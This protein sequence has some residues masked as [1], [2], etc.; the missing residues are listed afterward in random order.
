MDH[1]ELNEILQTFQIIV[2]TR[3][4]NTPR[5]SERFRAFGA[6][7]S[8]ATLDYGD[9]CGNILLPAGSLYD[10]SSRI[11]PATVIERK[12]S[13]DELAGCFTRS[14]DRFEREFQRAAD[15][16][17]RIYLLTENG[18]WEAIDKHRYR[19]KYNPTAFRASL[20]AW[21]IRYGIVP[22]F[23]KAE[24]SGGL[25]REILYRDIKERLEQGEYRQ[26]IYQNLP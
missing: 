26:R 21:S 23:C 5:A 20:I 16:G 1:F 12:M 19:S 11:S 2:D 17:A 8:R 10:T 13:L 4:Q 18:S 9:Y 6:P 22:I 3:E 15:H 14:R 25:I 7:V 24:T